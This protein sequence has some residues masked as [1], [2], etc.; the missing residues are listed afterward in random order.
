MISICEIG[1]VA[2]CESDILSD[3]DLLAVGC[4]VE[5]EMA[6][7]DYKA[8]GWNIAH[9]SWLEFNEMA[10]S[11]SLFVQH[12]KQDGRIVRD[13]QGYLRNLLDIY[14]P[15]C[16]YT[17]QLSSAIKPIRLFG[18]VESSY[19]GKLFQAD[20]LY[21]AVRNAC[22]LHRATVAEPEF[23]FKRLI[24][25]ASCIVGLTPAEKDT[26][27]RLRLLKHAYR[28]RCTAIDVSDLIE[29]SSATRK[30]ANY[31]AGLSCAT[32][33]AKEVS[34]GYFEMRALEGQLVRAVGPVYM[35]KLDRSHELTELW[36]TICNSDPYKPRPPRLQKWSKNVSDFLA[37]QHR[38]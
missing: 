34:N 9:Y 18:G 6:V 7:S 10:Q 29:I 12:V 3:K 13:D 28:A 2:R 14:R 11:Q 31:W 27:L 15:N 26:L 25:W 30:L 23:D 36:S 32:E 21:V 4:S 22:I 16:N 33:N 5:A 37:W 19:W 8:S 20:I 24:D 17:E 35:D 1:S 38:H